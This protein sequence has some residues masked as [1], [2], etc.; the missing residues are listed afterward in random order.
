MCG[1]GACMARGVCMA[2]GVHGR[3]HAWHG[4]VAHGRGTCMVGGVH[5]RVACMA[6]CV[7]RGH[8]WHAC[9][10]D[11]MRYGRSMHGQ[12]TSYWNALLFMFISSTVS[13]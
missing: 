6:L 12:Y 5:G 3:G 7:V 4:G 9:P 10:P 11:T 2:G 8:A 1:S 13:E